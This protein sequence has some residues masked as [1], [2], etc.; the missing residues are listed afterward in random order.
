M[1]FNIPSEVL[2]AVRTLRDAGFG[3]YLVGGCV[4]DLLAGLEPNDWDIA[5]QALPERIQALFSE[6]VYENSFGTVG[7]KTGS[8]D[9]RLAIVEVTTYRTEGSYT[10]SRRPDSVTFVE[11]IEDDLARRDFTVNAIALDPLDE[12]TSTSVVDPFGGRADLARRL[13]R[14]VGDP[15]ERFAEDA[16]RLMRAVRL[17]AQLDFEIE[18]AT[19]AALTV[20]APLIHSVAME[21][22][23]VELVKTL[24]TPRAAWGIELLRFAGIVREII[25]ELSEGVGVGQNKHHRY[26]VWEHLLKSLDYAAREGYP[27]SVR[28]AALL[29]DVGKP[30]TKQGEGEQCTFYAHEVVGASMAKR[31]LE[32]LRFSEE[33][34]AR[35]TLLV[36]SHMFKADEEVTE[37]A[38]RRLIRAVG[39]ENIWELVN[40]RTADR[41]GSGVP[42]AWP[43]RLRS[44]MALIEKNL[45][46][47]TSLKQMVLKGDRLME[48]LGIA[49]GPRVG[50]TLYALFEEVLD[51]PAKN[52]LPYLE[53]RA[54]ELAAL[55][56]EELQAL[57]E[58]GREE[59]KIA[60]EDEE[61]EIRRQFGVQ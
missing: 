13:I 36:R 42:K 24:M 43:Y 52:T 60:L 3:A 26:T 47:P 6:S 17:A 45:R 55:S 38:V 19:L 33:D 1:Q 20:A 58:R 46:E 25:P 53:A 35:I 50:W 12:D 34:I 61:G 48:L 49:P 18:P 14:A 57:A 31:I 30:R 8:E 44:Y 56:D 23:R 51:D 39:A 40:L 4:R 27:L 41:I 29:H 28:L 10:D 9:P 37:A 15:A 5:T 22:V 54:R 16:L 32:R 21:R 2:S 11:R 7:V 59:L